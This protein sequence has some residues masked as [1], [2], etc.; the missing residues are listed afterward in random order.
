MSGRKPTCTDAL[1]FL[2]ANK[3]AMGALTGQD[4]RA[5]LAIAHVWELYA[6]S[7]NDGRAASLDAVRALLDAMQPKC[8]LFAKE[9]IAHSM[10]WTDRDRLWPLVCAD[11][12][13]TPKP[14][15]QLRLVDGKDGAT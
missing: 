13:Q 9:L 3:H 8:R 6:A 12:A 11:D 4:M 14:P 1:A 7:D 10:D 5:L 15:T 2:R